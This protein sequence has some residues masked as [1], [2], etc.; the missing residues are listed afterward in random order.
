M[1][2]VGM[3]KPWLLIRLTMRNA[4]R[5]RRRGVLAMCC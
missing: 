2:I 3:R 1:L 4:L 5:R